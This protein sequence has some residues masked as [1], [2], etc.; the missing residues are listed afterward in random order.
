MQEGSQRVTI[1]TSVIDHTF[2]YDAMPTVL[3][4]WIPISAPDTL[5]FNH[6]EFAQFEGD[7]ETSGLNDAQN[8]LVTKGQDQKPLYASLRGEATRRY[9]ANTD[10][11]DTISKKILEYVNK[12]GSGAIGQHGIR[13]LKILEEASK[14]LV[15]AQAQSHKDFKML[16]DMIMPNGILLDDFGN[17]IKNENKP[18][19][20]SNSDPK[21]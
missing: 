17:P 19:E 14:T 2:Y 15:N 5:L 11:N 7:E 3:C 21:D 10:M 6:L 12:I 9:Q 1:K 13:D 20:K 8:K 18:D 4:T 16:K